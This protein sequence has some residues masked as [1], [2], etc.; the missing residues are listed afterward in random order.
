MIAYCNEV[1]VQKFAHV[2]FHLL[3]TYLGTLLII[4]V[5]LGKLHVSLL[6]A[7]FISKRFTYNIALA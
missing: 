5:V 1:L 7:T 3:L 4:N 6:S 2:S